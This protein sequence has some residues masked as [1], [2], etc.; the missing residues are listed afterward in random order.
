MRYTIFR[1]QFSSAVHFGAGGLTTTSNTLMADT[2][3]SALCTEAARAGEEPKALIE[4]VREG[5]LRISDALPYIQDRY[6]IPKPLSE[7]LTEKEGDSSVKKA[8]KKLTYLPADSLRAYMEGTLDIEKEAEILQKELGR[9]YLIE[10]AAI[11]TEDK[12]NP[13]AVDLYRYRE[14][15][16]LY[17]CIGYASDAEYYLFSDMLELLSF[18]GIGGKTTSGYGRFTPVMVKPDDAFVS[19]LTGDKWGQYMSLS[20]CLPEPGEMQEAMEGA[21]LRICKRSGWVSANAEGD[22]LRKRKDLYMFASG[23]VFS[24]RFR[25]SLCDLSDGKGHPVFRYAYPMFMG[26]I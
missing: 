20:V 2:V 4:A 12:T 8:L 1:L 6:Y 9:E 18:A 25:G 15:S 10:K 14:G 7:V 13:F 16:G 17:I 23:S 5:R 24:S 21:N 19:R 22:M 26:V 3:F 11:W